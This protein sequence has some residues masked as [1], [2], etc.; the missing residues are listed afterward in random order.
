MRPFLIW[1]ILAAAGF[2]G[3]GLYWHTQLTNDPRQVLVVV[4]ASFP[5]EAEWGDM[6]ALLRELSAARYAS[7]ALYTDKGKVHSWRGL[8]ALGTTTPYAPRALDTL[9]I[10]NGSAELKQADRR[11]LIT[12]APAD[13]LGAWSGWDVVRP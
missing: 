6:P 5:M 1:L 8:L 2:G 10:L 13:Q 12:N 7:F 11:I 3:T 9:A 4:D